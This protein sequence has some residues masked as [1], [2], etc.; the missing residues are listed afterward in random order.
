MT[1]EKVKRFLVLKKKLFGNNLF[2]EI[3]T[4]NPEWIEYSELAKDYLQ[5]INN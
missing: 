3:N 4:K 2:V 5:I 1:I